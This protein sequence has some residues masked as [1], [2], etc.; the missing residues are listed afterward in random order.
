MKIKIRDNKPLTENIRWLFIG[1]I[2]TNII[3]IVISVFIIR[4]L[5]VSDFGIY[6][7]FMGSLVIFS[8]FSINPILVSLKRFIPELVQKKYYSYLK[9]TIVQLVFISFLLGSILIVVVFMMR[10]EIGKWLNIKYFSDYY[11]IFIIN[12]ILFLIITIANSILVSFQE[13]KVISTINIFGMLVR[14]V[15]YSIFLSKITLILIFIIEAASQFVK[16]VP[17]IFFILQKLKAFKR[18]EGYTISK[19]EKSVNIKR[20]KRFTSFSIAN[21]AG[22]GILSQYSDY[23]FVSGVLGPT[24]VGLYA[25]AYK[26][27]ASVFDW[28]P[29][30]QISEVIKP[31]FIKKYYAENESDEYLEKMYNFFLK[32]FLI[33][34]SVIAIY[35]ISY[36]DIINVYIFKSKYINSQVILI[37]I[38]LS[39]IFRAI[40]FPAGTIME[41][42]EK[43]E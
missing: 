3:S 43:M 19:E 11:S 12:I 8:V 15:L 14:G 40:S 7:M 41:I 9:S 10:N 16:A 6:S 24:A 36:Q 21:E 17:F 4:K 33:L 22:S 5:A 38:L 30:V 39:F 29:V 32:I 26:L 18:I 25:F 28:L 2:L 13:Q 20:I 31:F 34:Y 35:L 23:Y 27:L 37:I 1:N 42:K